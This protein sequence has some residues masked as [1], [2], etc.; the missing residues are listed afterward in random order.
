MTQGGEGGG[1]AP[2]GVMPENLNLGGFGGGSQMWR[3]W[4]LE[5]EG[6]WASRSVGRKGVCSGRW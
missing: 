2:V 4:G 6:S 1:R 3:R 5:R